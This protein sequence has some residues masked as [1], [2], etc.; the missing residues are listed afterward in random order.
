[1]V[2]R[3]LDDDDKQTIENAL[4][5]IEEARPELERAKMAGI[6][7]AEAEASMLETEQKLR[8]IKQA[9]FP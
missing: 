5:K 2:S 9:F 8:K 4:S 7:V 1:M 6:D 3:L